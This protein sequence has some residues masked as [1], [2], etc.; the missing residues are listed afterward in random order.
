MTSRPPT[1]RRATT[2]APS[3]MEIDDDQLVEVAELG[4][5]PRLAVA[6][7]DT[8]EHVAHA[9]VSIEA[10]GH[11]VAT[12]AAGKAG[13]ERLVTLLRE[14]Q[15]PD[16]VL[17]AWPGGEPVIDAARALEP[18]RPVLIA[19]VAPPAASAAR[20][21]HAAGVDL[22]TLR[23]HDVERLGPVLM[24][25]GA[26]AAE[27]GRSLLAEGTEAMLRARLARHG[28]HDTATGFQTFEQFKRIMELELKRARRY[29]YALSVCQLT[30]I[31]PMPAPPGTI[32]HELRM[33]AAA[34]IG[35]AIRDIDFPVEIGD[36]R[37]LVLLP[38]TEA[39]GATQV[40]RRIM[41]TLRDAAPVRGGGRSWSPQ[42]SAGV[43]GVAAGAPVSMAQLIRA[44]GDAVKTARTRNVPLVVAP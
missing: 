40:A 9:R 28:E 25:A 13:V 35:A 29:G 10:L 42:V 21:A 7:H 27:R 34:A 30:M 33:R 17:I 18:R 14:Q 1:Q 31:A 38:Y 15:P 12:A 36:D 44:V 3:S 4:S 22:V 16:V 32:A 39:K 43:A 6:V 19:T 8:T 2:R 20:R 37:F 41:A 24:A 11:S 23:P 5:L 26:L